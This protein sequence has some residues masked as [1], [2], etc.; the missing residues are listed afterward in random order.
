MKK[1]TLFKA[2][3]L[4]IA[5][6][7]VSFGIRTFINQPSESEPHSLA[8][9]P[10]PDSD[11]VF[12]KDSMIFALYGQSKAIDDKSVKLLNDLVLVFSYNPKSKK[13]VVVTLPTQLYLESQSKEQANKLYL[14]NGD[15]DAKVSEINQAVQEVIQLP[16]D[17]YIGIDLDKFAQFVD[18]VDGLTI[19]EQTLSGSEVKAYLQ[20]NLEDADTT[21][22]FARLKQ[23]IEALI[24]KV[25]ASDLLFQLS[26][27]SKANKFMIDHNFALNEWTK[28]AEMAPNLFGNVD[29]IPLPLELETIDNELYQVLDNT[30]LTTIKDKLIHN[31]NE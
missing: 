11:K 10:E 22:Q 20:E 15:S 18:D 21:A 30:D 12:G 24:A 1:L 2:F 3:I 29:V 7:A 16:I 5:L 8:S 31:N 17:R 9:I 19:N 14:A 28:L 25:E 4:I 23:V 27:L 6:F 26:L 13:S